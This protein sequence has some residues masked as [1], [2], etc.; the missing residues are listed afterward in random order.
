[1]I[2]G[3][4]HFFKSGEFWR[5]VI[6]RPKQVSGRI[7]FHETNYTQ[8]LMYAA[9]HASRLLEKPLETNDIFE[10]H[11]LALSKVAFTNYGSQTTTD[12]RYDMR[13]LGNVA[14]SLSDHNS[15]EAGMI[16]LLK[17]IRDHYT[18]YY[19][20]ASIPTSSVPTDFPASF[21]RDSEPQT[22]TT[23]QLKDFSD[24]QI[25]I[26][27]KLLRP[28][29]DPR[30]KTLN[31]SSYRGDLT[32]A[33]SSYH[34]NIA[35]ADTLDDSDERRKE[36]LRAIA[37]FCREGARIHPF[38]DGNGRI[39]C[40]LLPYLLCLQQGFS[41]PLLCDPNI[42]GNYA[43]DEIVT[44]FQAGFTRTEQLLNG[45]MP[46]GFPS[47][48]NATDQDLRK[49]YKNLLS[50]L[51]R[52]KNPTHS[53]TLTPHIDNCFQ[54]LKLCHYI[55]E[56]DL[57]HVKLLIN[58]QTKQDYL[59]YKDPYQQS[60]LQLAIRAAQTAIARVL[61]ESGKFDPMYRDQTKDTA[62]E[63]AI[64]AG[65]S[66]LS[67]AM[68]ATLTPQ[69]LAAVNPRTQ[70]SPL[71][72]AIKYNRP[73]IAEVIVTAGTN[74][75]HKNQKQDTALDCAICKGMHWLCEVMIER[76]PS[77]Q[78]S[79][80]HPRLQVTPLMLAIHRNQPGIARKILRAGAKNLEH[81]NPE[82]NTA[83][84]LAFEQSHTEVTIILITKMTISQL[85]RKH[86]KTHK[87]LL[88]RALQ[89]GDKRIIAALNKKLAVAPP[90]SQLSKQ[91]RHLVY[92]N[93]KEQP[94]DIIARHKK[95]HMSLG[96]YWF[97]TFNKKM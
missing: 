23:G 11:S 9:S 6:D 55:Y 32:Q 74:L 28:T 14:F 25:K 73:V 67:K 38:M 61:W 10:L 77:E 91:S 43:I 97:E 7:G 90:K 94:Q 62:L 30:L 85:Q 42:I 50:V 46:H 64:F 69:Q 81:R 70:L 60:A 66:K 16:E 63:W 44:E 49:Y 15:S 18:G 47:Q 71:L 87:T 93:V 48:Y 52:D 57:K 68:I 8:A 53:K 92:Q 75:T 89:K 95:S 59:N 84:D 78:L 22:I 31:H 72:L 4:I 35:Y 19:V 96:Q 80:I 1:M 76:I 45:T 58:S 17:N 29:T 34:Q 33:V 13:S 36:K 56:G 37:N 86:P 39:F 21:H 24:V 83:L 82:Q 27:A 51:A 3:F 79:A 12:I 65:D 26:L 88:E 54:F 5:L 40:M 2:Y 41:I 20:T